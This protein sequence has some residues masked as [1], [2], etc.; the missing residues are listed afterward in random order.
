MF[1]GKHA[2]QDVMTYL[3]EVERRHQ[4]CHNYLTAHPSVSQRT[5]AI[6]VDWLIQVQV[7]RFKGFALTWSAVSG[8]VS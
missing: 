5:R 2:R 4:R 7:T 3:L 6:L 1:D 8:L